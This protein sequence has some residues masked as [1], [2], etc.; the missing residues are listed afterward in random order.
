M[1]KS[2]VMWLLPQTPH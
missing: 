1:I 2:A